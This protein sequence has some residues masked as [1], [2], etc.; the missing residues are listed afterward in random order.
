MTTR[1]QQLTEAFVALSDTLGMNVDPLVLLGRLVHHSVAL[2]SLDAAGVMLANSRGGLRS[3]ITTE[4]AAELTE[5]WQAETRQG[6][7]IDAFTTCSPVHA[8]DLASQ[9]D[10][11]PDF[12]PLAR[13]AGYESAHALP[14]HHSGQTI[15]AL[16]L[17]AHRPTALTDA[18]N[19]LLRALADVATTAVLSWD[20]QPLRPEDI[21][22]RTQVALAGKAVFD[23]ASGM[24]AATADITPAQG[25]VRLHAYADHHHLRPTDVADQLVRRTLDP[26]VVLTERT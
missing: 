24:L 15:G 4:H 7:C 13:A 8:P 20:R 9:K 19:L 25:A 3:A 10:R 5:I 22:T 11:W 17:L 18:D 1:E 21:T 23:T 16:N 26:H 14:L 12:V 6:P 2:T